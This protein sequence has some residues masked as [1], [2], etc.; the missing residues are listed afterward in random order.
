MWSFLHAKIN[1]R[2]LQIDEHGS[3]VHRRFETT[4]GRVCLVLFFLKR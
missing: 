1:A 2:I 3:D 4:P